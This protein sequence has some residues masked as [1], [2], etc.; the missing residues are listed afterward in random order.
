MLLAVAEG[1][2]EPA[3]APVEA[4]SRMGMAARKLLEEAGLAVSDITPTGPRGIVTKGDVL[5]AASGRSQ[6]AAGTT[7]PD[8]QPVPPRKQADSAAAQP[9]SKD[10]PAQADAQP[11]APKAAPAPTGRPRRGPRSDTP[12]TDIP[13]SQIRKIIA[14]RLLESKQTIPHLYLSADADLA[15][16]QKMRET[17]KAQGIKVSIISQT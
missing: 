10:K 1:H 14:Q 15:D 8:A 13:N 5:A 2:P 16:V 9:S 11:E 3:A 6:P 17:M 12:Y 7:K 4:N